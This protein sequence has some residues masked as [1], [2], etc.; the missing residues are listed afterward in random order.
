MFELV[1][2]GKKNFEHKDNEALMRIF[3]ALP[4]D[5]GRIQNITLIANWFESNEPLGTIRQNAERYAAASQCRWVKPDADIVLKGPKE[6]ADQYGADEST[7]QWLKHGEMWEQIEAEAA[8]TDLP[9]GPTFDSKMQR[10]EDLLPDA[11][12]EVREIADLLRSDW[13]RAIAFERHISDR[14]PQLHT[15]LEDGRRRLRLRVLTQNPTDPW[16]AL[17]RSQE[18]AEAVFS[19]DFLPVYGTARVRDLASGETAR[20]VGACPVNWKAKK[21]ANGK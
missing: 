16:D 14:L 17:T 7:M 4:T 6:F 8:T 13:Q 9:D 1:P 12:A 18:L 19:D 5:G 21:S 15:A 2:K 10:A 11:R 3:G 20:L